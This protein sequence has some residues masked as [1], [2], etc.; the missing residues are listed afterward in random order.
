MR[1]ERGRRSMLRGLDARGCSTASSGAAPTD[2]RAL[3]GGGVSGEWMVD[4]RRSC[5]ARQ[6]CSTNRAQMFTSRM[7]VVTAAVLSG[8]AVVIEAVVAG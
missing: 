2:R 3:G 4:T 6:A 7:A 5:H 8:E 1:W